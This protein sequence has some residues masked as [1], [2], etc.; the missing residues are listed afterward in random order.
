MT[1][2]ASPRV[3]GR[4][5]GQ[6]LA[7][8]GQDLVV[9]NTV[10]SSLPEPIIIIR[11][12]SGSS[13]SIDRSIKKGYFELLLSLMNSELEAILNDSKCIYLLVDTAKYLVEL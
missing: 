6:R 13:D 3:Q 9:A 1:T 8:Q 12:C 11:I 7:H 4:S 10:S 5:Q 2:T